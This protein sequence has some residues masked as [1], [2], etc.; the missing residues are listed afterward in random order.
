MKKTAFHKTAICLVAV[1]VMRVEIS[2][3]TSTLQA[4]PANQA[5]KSTQIVPPDSPEAAATEWP[6][7]RTEH[8]P[9]T[10]WWWL[11]SAVDKEN[12]S[13]NLQSLHQAG[14]GSVEITP[15]YGVQGEEARDIPYLSPRWMEMLKHVQNQAAQLDMIVDMN[16]GTGWPFGG[17]EIDPAHAASRQ[18]V[19]RYPL[20]GSSAATA[21]ISSSSSSNTTSTATS[22]TST[23]NSKSAAKQR[24]NLEVQDKRQQPHAQLQALL[25]VASDGSREILPL[26]AVKDNILE[27]PADKKGE[28]IALFCGKTLQQVKRSAPGGEGLVMNHLSK[29][30]LGHYL[31][32]FDRAFEQSDASWPNAFF[33]DSYEVYGAD[34]SEQLLEE[35]RQRRA[36][37]LRLYLPELLGEGDPEIIARVVCDYRETIAE[38]LLDN[39]TV[40]W[41]EWAHARGSKT[42]NQAHGSPGNL[43][44]LYA[45]MDIPECESF[46]C[47]NFDLPNLRVD[48]D[49][50]RNDGNPATLKYASSA[51]HVSGKNFT[52]SESMTWLTEH[53]RTSLALIKPEMDQ[54]FLNGVNRVYYHGTPYTPKEAAWPGWLFYASILVNPNNTIFRDMPALNDYIARVQSFMQ[55]G[56]PDNELLLYLPIYDIWQNYRK[57][58]YLTF[59]IHSMADKLPQFDG[60]VLE[61]REAG[62]DMDYIS[63]KQLSETKFA[64]GLLQTPGAEYKAIMVPHC[65]VMPPETLQHLLRLARQGARVMFLGSVPQEVPGLHKAAERRDQLRQLWQETGLKT[66]LHSQQSVSYGQGTLTVAPDLAQLMKT[67][68]IEPEEMKSV[69]G[70]DYIRRRYDDGYVYFVAMQHNR[71]VD[72]WVPLAKPASSVMFF[73]PLSGQK[74][75]APMSRNEENQNLVYLQIKP[76]QSLI[77]RTFDQ[78]NLSGDTYPVFEPGNV[79]YGCRKEQRNQ[80]ALPLSGN[81]TFEFSEGQPHIPGQFKMKGQPRPWTELQVEGADAYAGTGVYK[82]EFKLPKVQADDW[83]LDFGFLAE[84]A[85]IRINGKDAGLVWSVPYE[86]RLGD[87]LLPG[88]KNSIEIAVTNLPANRIADY[89][90]RGIKW[91]IF[92]DINIVSV[93]YKPIT[94]DVWPV[95]PSGLTQAPRLIPLIHIK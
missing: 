90:R 76:G 39:F 55:S 10:R 32:K 85:R 41:T 51:A 91:R 60:L 35:F 74:A 37:D 80:E 21:T 19:Q 40:P 12:L 57:S 9:G 6:E 93:F 78:G 29:E 62:Y 33:N 24:I 20:E 88:K 84:T 65:R 66:D 77:I 23:S 4:A 28:L 61:L 38:M 2:G 13:W 54:L 59:V 94:F 27:L 48:E 69:Q 47:T 43:L 31:K 83:L 14:I 70:L 50:R 26:E 68:G 1:M 56:K 82:L 52:S 15:I 71:S 89:D 95:L 7:I 81:W 49:I 75:P 22:T 92:K 73:D 87:Y 64:D 45:A 3:E 79:S 11:G 86:I 16:G 58:N 72:A 44:D 30:A 46:G 5:V 53:F 8:K 42:R 17:P 67:S 34:W 36:Y 25:F 63:D 18:L